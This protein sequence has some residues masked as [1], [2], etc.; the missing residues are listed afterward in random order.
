MKTD[1]VA[2]FEYSRRTSAS[3]AIDKANLLR[4]MIGVKWGM[5]KH[6]LKSIHMPGF[7]DDNINKAS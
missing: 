2:Y 3:N 5:M 4:S 7:T 6:P 1:L